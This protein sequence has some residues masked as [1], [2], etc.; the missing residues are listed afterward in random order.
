MSGVPR[1][2]WV[3]EFLKTDDEVLGVY[4]AIQWLLVG[5]EYSKVEGMGF[6]LY[7]LLRTSM[8]VLLRGGLI[9]KECLMLE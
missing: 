1:V 3:E 8:L 2:D 4:V 9:I 6:G 5:S 7:H